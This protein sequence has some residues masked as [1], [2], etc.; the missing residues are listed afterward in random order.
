[1]TDLLFQAVLCELSVVGQLHLQLIMGDFNV[2]HSKIPCLVEGISEGSWIV[3]D[4]QFFAGRGNLTAFTCKNVWDSYWN[5]QGLCH[6]LPIC[7]CCLHWEL[8]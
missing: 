3:F 4:D 6:D 5:P 2:E 7:F 1:M 8:G